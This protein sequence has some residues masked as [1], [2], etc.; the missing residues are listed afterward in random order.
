MSKKWQA[1]N[2]FTAIEAIIVI[3]IIGVLASALVYRLNVSQSTGIT[4]AAD[5]LIADIRY[6]QAK[7]MGKGSQHSMFFVVGSET[8]SIF[9]VDASGTYI[10]PGEQKRLTDGITVTSTNLPVTNLP[11]TTQPAN[12]LTFNT[13]GEPTFGSN[14]RIITLSGSRTLTVY[15]ITGKVE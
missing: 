9:F 3:I 6:I 14:D 2:G 13:L 10:L 5:Q 7:A 12:A 15:A 8:Y 1:D 11:G 4:V